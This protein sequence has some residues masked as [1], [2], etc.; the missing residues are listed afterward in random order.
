MSLL[1]SFFLF[2]LRTHVPRCQ[3][4]N[5]TGSRRLGA[6]SLSSSHS[7]TCLSH[8]VSHAWSC[9]ASLHAAS[10]ASAIYR[11]LGWHPVPMPTLTLPLKF[12]GPAHGAGCAAPVPHYRVRELS[13]ELEEWAAVTARLAPLN[14]MFMSPLEGTSLTSSL[15]SSLSSPH[16]T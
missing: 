8:C 4:W 6:V 11:R 9:I 13:W 16:P 5:A 15:S 14:T 7:F 3:R 12:G 10:A 1:V 2:G